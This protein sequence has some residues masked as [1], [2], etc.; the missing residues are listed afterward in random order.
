MDDVIWKCWAADGY[1]DMKDVCTALR[2]RPS[3]WSFAQ[4]LHL[5]PV[6]EISGPDLSDISLSNISTS[7]SPGRVLWVSAQGAAR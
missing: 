4:N 7:S 3:T 6:F 5:Y 1:E 2:S